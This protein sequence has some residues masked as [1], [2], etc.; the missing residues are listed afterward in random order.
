MR[1]AAATAVSSAD[2]RMYDSSDRA[3]ACRST[4][5]P[6]GHGAQAWKSAATSKSPLAESFLSLS[7]MPI[8]ETILFTYKC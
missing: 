6:S 7:F 8:Q 2:S 5:V 3:E 4:C 1:S